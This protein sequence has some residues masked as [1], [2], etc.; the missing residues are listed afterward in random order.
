MPT[1]VLLLVLLVNLVVFAAGGAYL[2]RVQTE[3]LREEILNE[4]HR[5]VGDLKGNLIR[6]EGPT[7][8]Y[9]LRS[10]VWTNFADSVLVDRRLEVQGDSIVATG[11][12]LN[13]SGVFRRPAA[14]DRE[15]VLFAL[16]QAIEDDL[17]LGGVLDGT[18]IPIAGPP[19]EGNWGGL[20][21]RIEGKEPDRLGLLLGMLPWFGVSTVLL[22]LGSF[23]TL[24]RL[25]L[26]PVRQLAV[27]ARRVTEGDFSYQMP[28]PDRRDELAALV[29]SFNSMTAKVSSFNHILSEEV[30]V[31]TRKAR[32]AEAAAMRQRRLAAM[33]ELAAGLAHEI[34]NP[35]GGL[36]NAVTTLEKGELSEERR[37][38]YL[39]LL[40]KGLARIGETVARLRRFT[41]R[42]VPMA[43]VDIVDAVND[44]VALVR[45]R[46]EG[47]G[48]SISWNAPEAEL[49]PVM[50]SRTEIGQALLNL[51]VNAL[52]ALQEGGTQDSRGMWIDVTLWPS[53]GGVLLTVRDNGPGVSE[54][55]LERVCDLFFTTKDVGKGSGLG[56]A[57]VHNTLEQHGGE[58]RLSSELGR[59]FEV[60]LWFPAAPGTGE[61]GGG[62]R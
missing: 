10:P 46:A 40:A 56:L 2:S 14:F 53:D 5:L 48:V 33:G 12:D 3:K 18:I 29:R 11:I 49:S 4:A 36:Q 30:R 27:A 21:Y 19:G 34:N 6:E 50:G 28:E 26:D 23:F 41:P 20:W 51:L 45:H 62:V 9:I 22:T 16:R 24:K 44:G 60:G 57:L 7:L 55:E 43:K 8:D 17:Q 38:S 32:A 25:V 42:E 61:E 58:V 52:D 31:A 47:M 35:L 39:G 37:R 1:R 59:F 13:P 15:A 54:A